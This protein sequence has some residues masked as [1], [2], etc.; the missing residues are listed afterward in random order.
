MLEDWAGAPLFVRDAHRVALTAAGLAFRPI[1]HEIL[2][3]MV[4][5]RDQIRDAAQV[6]SNTLRFACTSVLSVS[7]FP[8]WLQRLE[9]LNPMG[10][11]VSLVTD[12][13]AV[14]RERLML[15]GDAQLLLCYH[16]VS[17][18][19]TLDPAYFESLDVGEDFLIPVSAP[20]ASNS[21]VPLHALPGSEVAP[22]D[23]LAFSHHS[24]IG[25]ILAATRASDATPVW[26]N[27]T[28]TAGMA[29][30]L[31]AVARAGRGVAWLPSSLVDADLRLGRLV[32]SGDSAWDIPMLIRLFRPRAPQGAVT[33]TFWSTVANN[34]PE[35]VGA[36]NVVPPFTRR[37]S[38]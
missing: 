8:D 18:P 6:S 31:I 2:R 16:H 27:T 25:R 32:R 29:I 23:Y 5:A 37:P 7:F 24:G 19:T 38:N 36:H 10:V 35:L 22:V 28:F 14:G 34:L 1:A 26:L 21:N 9:T 13:S 3:R 33:E 11:E 15:Q 20:D 17:A 4:A 12:N 30:V